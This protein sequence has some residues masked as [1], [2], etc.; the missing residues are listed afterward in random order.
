MVKTTLGASSAN[1]FLPWP[2]PGP[3]RFLDSTEILCCRAGLRQRIWEVP[4]QQLFGAVGVPDADIPPA[5]PAADDKFEPAALDLA[6]LD[7][8]Y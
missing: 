1:G 5:L 4:A 2:L 6:I 3:P 7:W 8:R